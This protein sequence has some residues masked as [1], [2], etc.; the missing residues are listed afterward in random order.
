MTKGGARAPEPPSY[1]PV[2]DRLKSLHIPKSQHTEFLHDVF[3]NP[4]ELEGL[5]DAENKDCFDASL[6]SLQV[7][8]NNQER[9]FNDPP[10]FYDWF[11][12][13]CKEVVRSTMLK[14][15]SKIW[16]E[17]EELALSGSDIIY[18]MYYGSAWLVKST[19]PTHQRPFLWSVRR[20]AKYCVKRAVCF[21]I[22]M[23]CAHTL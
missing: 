12:C 6:I 10:V 11:I 7:I 14:P 19:V 17:S 1:A 23:E 15:A 21:L 9:E 18:I 2:E 3:G 16:C 13:N 5:V 4:A 20:Q 8:W 22:P